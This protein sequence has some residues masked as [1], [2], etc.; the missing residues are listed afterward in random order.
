MN[1]FIL[2]ILIALST[3]I[4]A[5]EQIA[6]EV[7]NRLS[8]TTKSYKNITIEFYFILENKSQNIREEQEGILVLAGEKFQ[9]EMHNQTIINNGETQWIYLID[10]NEV[11][12]MEHDPED[13][14]MSPNKFFTIY[15][16]DYKYTY[17]GANSEKGKR[18]QIIDLFPKESREFMKINIAVDAAKNQLE[19][20]TIHDKNGGT[21]KYLVTSFKSNTIIKP[22]IFNITDFPGVEVIDLR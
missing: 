16:A 7:L 18:L 13:K 6:K 14:M 15:E 8:T 2:I 3:T 4:F 21:Y 5:Q 10:M 17:V 19:R 20:I 1:K 22:F 11:Q 12:I 9:L